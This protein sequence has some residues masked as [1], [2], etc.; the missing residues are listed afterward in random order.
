[1]ICFSGSGTVADV[2][3]IFMDDIIPFV[4][5]HFSDMSLNHSLSESG[6]SSHATLLA[7]EVSL[8]CVSPPGADTY[9][10]VVTTHQFTNNRDGKEHNALAVN[11]KITSDD[12]DDVTI[13]LDGVKIFVLRQFVNE[14]LQYISSPDYGLGQLM[15]FEDLHGQ[16]NI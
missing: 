16:T 10:D 3:I 2:S 9:P 8:Q 13:C 5:L 7:S 15:N 12:D 1:M 14:L 6:D 11:I 4:R